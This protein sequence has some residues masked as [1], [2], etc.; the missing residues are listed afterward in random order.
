MENE[1]VVI[2][3][4]ADQVAK[5]MFE[6]TCN[7]WYL[8]GQIDERESNRKKTIKLRHGN[9]KCGVFV[10]VCETVAAVLFISLI[11]DAIAE[12]KKKKEETVDEKSFWDE[13]NG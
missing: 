2:N 9:F 6:A 11:K 12:H 5:K 7:F 1:K 4:V 3:P 13:P 8:R 10:G